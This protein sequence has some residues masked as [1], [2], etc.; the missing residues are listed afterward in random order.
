MLQVSI[1]DEVNLA[2]SVPAVLEDHP[3]YMSIALQYGRAKQAAYIRDALQ[4]VV[5]EVINQEDLDL[6]TNPAVVSTLFV[7]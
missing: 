4:G 5:H 3:T 7:V 2:A 1:S 6:E